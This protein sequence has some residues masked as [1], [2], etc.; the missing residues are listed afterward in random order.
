MSLLILNEVKFMTELDWDYWTAKQYIYTWQAAALV[1]DI[2]PRQIKFPRRDS[3]GELHFDQEN[4]EGRFADFK[5][6]LDLLIEHAWMQNFSAQNMRVDFKRFLFWAHN[7]VKWDMPQKLLSFAKEI[8]L[9]DLDENAEERASILLDER[10]SLQLIWALR[11]ML[12]DHQFGKTDRELIYYL[13]KQYPDQHGF[14][15]LALE[16][17]FAEAQIAS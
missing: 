8:N 1:L 9:Q 4:F 11:L 5:L 10:A 3:A 17:K 14:K 13:A 2:N 12:K 7:I 16:M 15:R 6:K